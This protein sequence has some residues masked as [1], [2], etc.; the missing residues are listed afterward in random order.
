MPKFVV[1]LTDKK[2]SKDYYVLYSTIVDSIVSQFNDL[3][4]AKQY[5][6]SN[7]I[8]SEHD[9]VLNSLQSTGVS[10]PYY[11]LDDVLFGND[12]DCETVEELIEKFVVKS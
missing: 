2:T 11:T 12:D 3:E 8:P 9:N 7:I 4:D 1:K 10:N 6:K 5:L